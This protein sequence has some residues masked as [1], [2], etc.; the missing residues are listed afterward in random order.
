MNTVDDIQKEFTE[1][2]NFF[3]DE[4]YKMRVSINAKNVQENYVKLRKIYTQI[5]NKNVKFCNCE[6]G[7][8]RM[9]IK[10]QKY[11]G[12]DGN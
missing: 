2:K 12:E 6:N 3:F 9:C 1:L 10:I 11:F 8:R 4:R 7:L 5:F